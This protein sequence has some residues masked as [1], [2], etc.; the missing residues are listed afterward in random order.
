MCVHGCEYALYSSSFLYALTLCSTVLY[1]IVGHVRVDVIYGNFW[2][3]CRFAVVVLF[4]PSTHC[5]DAT[6][7]SGS[8]FMGSENAITHSLKYNNK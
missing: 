6:I 5:S 2:Y 8:V 4:P 3:L 1:F 7:R